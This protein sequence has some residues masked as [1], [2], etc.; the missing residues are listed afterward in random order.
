MI[1]WNLNSISILKTEYLQRILDVMTSNEN[2]DK[3]L[4]EIKLLKQELSRKEAE[5]DKV[6]TNKPEFS[7]PPKC[8]D[9]TLGDIARYSRQMILP[10]LRPEG[11]RR[12][13]TSS[14]LIVGCGGKMK[15]LYC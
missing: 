14:A 2:Q 12:L 4:D 9:L 15:F 3:L 10:E 11:Q 6:R 8:Q 7:P 5:L 13:L 1:K